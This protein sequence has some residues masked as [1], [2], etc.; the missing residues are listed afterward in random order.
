M[1]NSFRSFLVLFG[2]LVFSSELVAVVDLYDFD[3]ASQRERYH[4][5]SE[6][7]R[8]PK[9]Q[10]QNLAGSDSQ[11]AEDL[12]RELHRLLLE[13]QTDKEIKNHMVARYGDFVLYKPRFQKATLVLWV[14]P[15]VLFVIGIFALSVVVN[16]RKA[17]ALSDKGVD[18]TM[19]NSALSDNEQSTLDTI[20]TP[21]S[22]A[23]PRSTS[24]DT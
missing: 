21:N 7:L 15:F 12:R 5:L 24:K 10:N 18:L 6:E 3:T 2:L 20:L 4:Q 11:I 17:N 16:R 23:T 9:C 19:D 14:L 8:C 1:R 22:G 13:G